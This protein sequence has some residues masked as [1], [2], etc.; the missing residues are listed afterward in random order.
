[1]GSP[2]LFFFFLCCELQICVVVYI[3]TWQLCTALRCLLYWIL[4]THTHC[5]DHWAHVF[6]IKKIRSITDHQTC[7]ILSQAQP[8]ICHLFFIIAFIICW[9]KH[10]IL[11]NDVGIF[12][13]QMF[14]MVDLFS[15]SLFWNLAC[16]VLVLL[17]TCRFQQQ[18]AGIVLLWMGMHACKHIMFQY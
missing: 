6:F 8:N 12:N 18:T 17:W 11:K 10:T 9:Q 1:M 5:G 16:A 4:G 14:L 7:W 13:K 3:D 15:C 2:W